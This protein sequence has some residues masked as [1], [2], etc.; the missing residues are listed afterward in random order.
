VTGGA[1]GND[2]SESV[3]LSNDTVPPPTHSAGLRYVSLFRSMIF[4]EHVPMRLTTMID[5]MTWSR[6]RGSSA[7]PQRFERTAPAAD[8]LHPIS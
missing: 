4:G 1:D 8:R 6:V 2:V 7:Q 5:E 3:N